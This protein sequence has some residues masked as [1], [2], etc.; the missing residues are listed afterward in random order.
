MQGKFDFTRPQI[1]ESKKDAR[2]PIAASPEFKEFVEM[3]ARKLGVSTSELG[4][5]YFVEGLQRDVAE[6]FLPEPHLDKSL[7]EVMAKF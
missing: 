7:R 2:I 5:R 3:M 6:T 4:H 1:Q